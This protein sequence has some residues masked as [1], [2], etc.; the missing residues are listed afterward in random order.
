MVG[1]L[2]SDTPHIL[3]VDDESNVRRVLMALLEQAGYSA[4]SASS[5]DEAIDLVRSQDPDLVLTDL[6]MPGTDGMELLRRL[7]EGFPE[8]PVVM[9]TA[10]GSV[11]TAV[12]A[13]KRGAFDFLTKPFEKAQVLEVVGKALGQAERSRHEFQGPAAAGASCGFAGSSEA[14]GKLCRMIEKVAPSPSTI[15]I[16]GETGTGKELVAEALHQGSLRPDGPMV[17]I[18]CGALPENLVEAELFGYERGAFTGADRA[19]PGRFELADGGT[20]FLDEIG[21]LPPAMQVKLLRVLQDGV[22]DRVGGVAPRTVDVRLLAATQRDLERSVQEGSFRQDLL[23]RLRVVELH[24]PPLRER[25]GDVPEL[26]A[27]FLEK[28]SRRLG[29]EP[30]S[31]SPEAMA[32]LESHSWPGNV[33][34]LQNAVERALLLGGATLEP[35]DFGLGPAA[36]APAGSSDLKEAARAAAEVVE[37]RMIRAALQTTGGNVTRAAER[38]GLS[39][40][41]L[42]LKMKE[43]GLRAPGQDEGA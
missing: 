29:R 25:A 15:L 26:A 8:I 9:L 22:I 28:Q 38:L 43:L 34:E 5:V 1:T 24:V 23:Y 18:N 32:L 11:E 40:R 41:G 4:V 7:R 3:L 16:T 31:I 12:E 27:F 30:A 6:R 33:R 42:Q 20:L 10:H 2:L 14:L 19:K 36:E 39:R 21:E 37:R 35:A 17:R 13:M